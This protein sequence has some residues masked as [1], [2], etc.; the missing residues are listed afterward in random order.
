MFQDTSAPLSDYFVTSEPVI[1]FTEPTVQLHPPPPHFSQSALFYYAQFPAA[2][3]CFYYAYMPLSMPILHSHCL[4]EIVPQ[5]LM[6]RPHGFVGETID[7]V[8]HSRNAK[9]NARV[10]NLNFSS[11]TPSDDVGNHK[12]KGGTKFD[13][14]DPACRHL[15]NSSLNTEDENHKP[16]NCGLPQLPK[17]HT[18]LECKKVS[19]KLL[20]QNG[21]ERHSNGSE[22]VSKGEDVVEES[23]L[24]DQSSC[25]SKIDP[26]VMNGMQKLTCQ[27]AESRL[28]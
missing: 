23:L 11:A 25:E 19:H 22:G 6:K 20:A 4:P 28:E 1:A 9:N 24:A 26:I 15:S 5:T 7:S 13:E 2:A 10:K 12:T 8:H 27:F 3:P 14:Q 16:D 17:Q 21:S 18:K